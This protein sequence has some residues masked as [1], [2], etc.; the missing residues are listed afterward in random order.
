[1]RFVQSQWV[2]EINNVTFGEWVK[3]DISE[4]ERKVETDSGIILSNTS[5]KKGKFGN[6]VGYS[7]ERKDIAKGDVVYFEKQKRDNIIEEFLFIQSSKIIG[8]LP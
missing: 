6:V 1:M 8:K 4:Q 7:G 3:V 5:I 2:F